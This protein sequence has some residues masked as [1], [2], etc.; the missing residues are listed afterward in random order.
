MCLNYPEVR[1]HRLKLLQSRRDGI[2]EKILQLEDQLSLVD[3][4]IGQLVE[5]QA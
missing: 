5:V 3:H 2:R 4:E 1:E